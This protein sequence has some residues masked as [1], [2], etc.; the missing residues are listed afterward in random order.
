M[1]PVCDLSVSRCLRDS[2]K[3]SDLEKHHPSA[4]DIHMVESISDFSSTI[5]QTENHGLSGQAESEFPSFSIDKDTILASAERLTYMT[6]VRTERSYA[7]RAQELESEF[8][9]TADDTVSCSNDSISDLSEISLNYPP[10]EPGPSEVFQVELGEDLFSIKWL[11]PINPVIGTVSLRQLGW[12]PFVGF[13]ELLAFR[14]VCLLFAA[15]SCVLAGTFTLQMQVYYPLM[16]TVLNCIAA[17]QSLVHCL[18]YYINR[19][20]AQRVNRQ[21][22]IHGVEVLAKHLMSTLS[23]YAT[24]CYLLAHGSVAQHTEMR[25]PERNHVVLA[26]LITLHSLASLLDV[27]LTPTMFRAS[28][29]PYPGLVITMMSFAESTSSLLVNNLVVVL[30]DLGVCSLIALSL[31]L[32]SRFAYFMLHQDRYVSVINGQK[33]EESEAGMDTAV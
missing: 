4:R 16:L 22:K 15:M 1:I 27:I 28:H 26:M 21:M 32:H 19:H 6:Y 12:S 9:C 30:S 24:V 29:I 7:S 3:L 25:D 13:R 2:E 33:N 23:V 5:R 10:S 20:D 14:I 8:S 31:V 17:L 18:L 11:G